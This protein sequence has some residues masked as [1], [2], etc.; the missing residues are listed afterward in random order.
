MRQLRALYQG[1]DVL[2][3]GWVV[4]AEG[5][6]LEMTEGV[7]RLDD[8]LEGDRTVAQADLGAL[9]NSDGAGVARLAQVKADEVVGSDRTGPARKKVVRCH[10]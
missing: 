7:A 5:Q 6:A 4:K 9:E 8:P 3:L 2:N 1:A 10:S